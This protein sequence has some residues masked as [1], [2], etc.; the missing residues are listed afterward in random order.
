MLA[1]YKQNA[2]DFNDADEDNL[3]GN[4][5]HKNTDI[6]VHG[7]KIADFLGQ[8]KTINPNLLASQLN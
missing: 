1:N 8:V 7:E 4:D 6:I 5:E 2:D 3:L